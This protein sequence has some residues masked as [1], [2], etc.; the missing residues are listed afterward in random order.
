MSIR[1][2]IPYVTWLCSIIADP[3]PP[4]PTWAKDHGAPTPDQAVQDRLVNERFHRCR[5]LVAGQAWSLACEVCA[6]FILRSRG[7]GCPASDRCPRLGARSPVG[8]GMAGLAFV[9]EVVR[10]VLAGGRGR[11]P[12]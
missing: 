3:S 9:T 1:Y 12:G 10:S 5:S 11:L 6:R 8:Y 4:G 2:L 7:L